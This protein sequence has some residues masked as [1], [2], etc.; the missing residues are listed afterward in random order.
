MPGMQMSEAQI[1]QTAQQYE[2]ALRNKTQSAKR[3][4]GII[5]EVENTIASLKELEKLNGK[6]LIKIGASVFVEV[7]AKNIKKCKRGFSEN[8]FVED[9]TKNTITWLKEKKENLK[10]NFEAEKEDIQKIQSGLSE[11]LSVL[12]QIQNEKQKNISVK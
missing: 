11:M 6:V 4:E 3:I 12:R 5:I 7:E 8:G 9:T 1:A 2:E 10:K